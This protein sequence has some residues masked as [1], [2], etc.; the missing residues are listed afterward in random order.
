VLSAALSSISRYGVTITDKP[1][2]FVRNLSREWRER[3]GRVGGKL[4]H[5]NRY[6]D[7]LLKLRGTPVQ[8]L[9]SKLSGKSDLK[10]E[11]GDALIRLC[12]S[13]W[14]YVGDRANDQSISDGAPELYRPLLSSDEVTEVATYIKG[15]MSEIWAHGDSGITLPG[16]STTA[17]IA[18]EFAKSDALFVISSQRIL[19]TPQPRQALIGFRD[20]VNRLW[21]IDRTDHKYRILVWVLDLGRQEF[22]DASRFWNVQEL[23]LRFRALKLFKESNAETRWNWLQSRA[24]IVLHEP[25]AAAHDRAKPP[26]FTAQDVL[27]SEIPH[28]WKGSQQI[29]TLYGRDL[30]R[31]ENATLTIFFRRPLEHLSGGVRPELHYFGHTLFAQSG[32]SERREARGLELPPPGENYE[33]ALRTIY[34]ASREFLGPS[35]FRSAIGRSAINVLHRLGFRLA[36]LEDFMASL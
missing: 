35:N 25:Q 2:Q 11:D 20:L 8:S 15:R 26:A 17:L 28:S 16:E 32:D 9:A 36:D 33:D 4:R 7:G 6:L 5:N 23:R 19:I 27:F 3:G 29:C 18:T 24:V 34:A 1:A 10:P 30:E 13:C 14:D 31:L 21:E 22:E 12:L